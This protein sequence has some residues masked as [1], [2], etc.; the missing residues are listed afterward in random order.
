VGCGRSGEDSSNHSNCI[1]HSN[2]L[3]LNVLYCQL[4]SIFNMKN[5]TAIMATKILGPLLKS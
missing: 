4:F 3:F 2:K 1:I 5:I